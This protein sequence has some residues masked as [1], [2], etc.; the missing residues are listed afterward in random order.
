MN[1]EL[2]TFEQFKDARLYTS[3]GIATMAAT[4][5]NNA[6]APFAFFA[7]SKNDLAKLKEQILKE[8]YNKYVIECVNAKNEAENHV[9]MPQPNAAAAADVFVTDE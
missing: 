7:S 2:L 5:A 9:A 8:M 1:V 4:V 6:S 3:E